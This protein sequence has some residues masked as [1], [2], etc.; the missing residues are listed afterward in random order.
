MIRA[1]RG[2]HP[3]EHA[4]ERAAVD[5]EEGPR[6]EEPHDAEH[7]GHDERRGHAHLEDTEHVAAGDGEDEQAEGN[8]FDADISVLCHSSASPTVRARTRRPAASLVTA[9]TPAAMNRA[10]RWTYFA[11]GYRSMGP[12]GE[13]V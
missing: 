4:L 11:M 12:L 13:G 1:I 7:A 10:K 2:N 3:L 9:V 6:R 5:A 8:S